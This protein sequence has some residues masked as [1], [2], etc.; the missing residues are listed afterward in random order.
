MLAASIAPSLLP[1]PT[2]VWI[3][4]MK[5]RISPSE[6]ITSFTTALSRSSNSPLYLAPAI[7]A[8]MSSEKICLLR[9]LSGTSPSMI[10]CAIPSAIAVLPTPGSPTRI[11]LFLV[12]RERICKTRRISSSRPIT[13]SSLPLR[14]CSFRLIAYLPSASKV[15]SLVCESIVEPLRSSLI[16]AIISFSFTPAS[17]SSLP[18]VP[19]SER[20][21]SN[22]CS[23]DAYL[24]LNS[25]V[26]SPAFWMASELSREK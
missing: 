5:S 12:R 16:A 23:T 8:P 13:G 7:S 2:S 21:P 14:A 17:F 22:R 25:R 15:C 20:I 9:R 19:F 11:G 24:S 10:R 3:S 18:A 4:S 1:A 26:K 6:E